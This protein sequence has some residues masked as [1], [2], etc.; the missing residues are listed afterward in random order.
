MTVQ[1]AVTYK[2]FIVFGSQII[3]LV[4]TWIVV[5]FQGNRRP[6]APEQG[7]S[8]QGLFS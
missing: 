3:S 8:S 4:S 5:C 6:W 1:P 2:V 7:W